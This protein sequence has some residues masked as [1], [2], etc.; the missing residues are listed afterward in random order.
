MTK[1][2]T[3]KIQSYLQKIITI[4][5]ILSFAGFLSLFP[6]QKANADI[7]TGL[8]GHWAL[9]EGSGTTA[10]DS[11]GNS[12]TGTFVDVPT[13]QAGRVGSGALQFDGTN[14][15]LTLA[16]PSTLN[17]NT[18]TISFWINGSASF[19][20][21]VYRLTKSTSITAFNS[22]YQIDVTPSSVMF[23]TGDGTASSDDDVYSTTLTAGS[24]WH[25]VCSLDG[26]N[27]KSCYRNGTLISSTTNDVNVTLNTPVAAYL[28]SGRP[29]T[30]NNNFEGIIDD[31]LVY[32]RALSESD[33][34]ELFA[35]GADT[36]DPSVPTNLATTSVSA[37]RIALSWNASTD[38][39]GVTGYYVYR[40]GVQIGSTAGTTYVNTGLSVNTTY[41]YTVTA[42]DQEGNESSQ[43]SP[44]EATTAVNTFEVIPGGGGD[45]TTIS[46][47]I[48]DTQPGDTCN[49]HAG[50]YLETVTP[51]VSGTYAY[52]ILIQTNSNDI[53]NL[54]GVNFDSVDF[55]HI[56]DINVQTISQWGITWTLDDYYKI[57]LFA[58]EDF[59][60]LGPVTINSISPSYDGTLNGWQVN[61]AVS[62]EQGFDGRVVASFNASLV[63]SLP[64]TTTAPTESIV[65]TISAVASEVSY[66]QTAAVLTVVSS[67][68]ANNGATI[69]RPPY[70]GTSKPIYTT[71]GLHTEYLSS[72]ASVGT[73]PSLATVANRFK[74]LRLEHLSFD[75]R[76]F[77]P[78]DAYGETSTDGYG[79]QVTQY[80]A[81]DILRLLLNDS[82]A[83]KMPA[84]IGVTQHGLD[85]AYAVIGGLR[86][87]GTGH[88]P[89]HALMA[90]F[91]AVMLDI[92]NAKTVL[93][94]ANDFEENNYTTTGVG[95]RSLWGLNGTESAYWTY[96]ISENGNRAN[97]DPYGFIDGGK[98]GATG[99]QAILSQSYKGSVLVGTLIPEI[100]TTAWNSTEWPILSGYAE[101]WVDTGFWAQPDPCAPYDGN[102]A[103][104]QITY[105]PDPA[106]PGMCILDTDL[107]YYNSSTDFAC[108]AGQ[109]CG[110]SYLIHGTQTDGGQ[111]KSN[112]VAAMW[113]AYYGEDFA[114]PIV[115]T[116]S[117][118][119]G[120]TDVATTSNLVLTFNE[121][122]AK[123][124]GNI[125]IK[126]TSDDSTAQTIDV[127]SGT[128][129][130][131]TNTVTINPSDFDYS[132]GYY[133]TMASGVL[134]DT[135]STPNAHA[136]ISNSTTWN[137]TTGA[138]PDSTTP[139]RSAGSP[140]G[141]QSAGTTQV[142]L[143]LTTDE[144]ATCKY[145]T[146][147][148]TAYGLM[149]D[150]FLTTGGTS[151]ST[152][153]SGLSNGQSYNYY[154]R[155]TDG[156]NANSDDY[157]ISFS[158]A[159]PA[160]TGGSSGSP[161]IW[162]LPIM[163]LNGF[164]LTINNGTPTTS[165]RNVT[166]NFN[167]GA[168]IKKMS[169]SMTRDFTDASQEDYTPTKQW[170]LCS[171]FG[172]LIKNP[173][174]PNGTYKV[175]A[176]FYTAYGRTSATALA[177]SSITL[178]TGATNTNTTKYNFTRNLSL[179]ATGKDV[180]ALQQ[181]LNANG[182]IISK[183]GAGSPG[184]ETTLFGALTYKALVKFQKSLGWSGT[185]FFGPMT[186][187]YIN[188]K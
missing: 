49:V 83:D 70:M 82:I 4:S 104:Y 126:K 149:T 16:T 168:D 109:Q 138:A 131:G 39:V 86:A 179:Y 151:H 148:G 9:D 28:A 87:P 5:L 157:T 133:I 130:V 6:P 110:R 38:N 129:N 161:A 102:P 187:A 107:Q 140:S 98:L 137:F 181:Y 143:S 69:F 17:A 13:W 163:P 156:S 95:G 172:G 59:W 80:N 54:T 37:S 147:A 33:I 93:V 61:P 76:D 55:V 7:T 139:V 62:A 97:K 159:S 8:L 120:A 40:N 29:D 58:N 21:T 45:Y 57:G 116:Y 176:Q 43:S 94:S 167:A 47:C 108:Q 122:V 1:F 74:K 134:T 145:S 41:S 18:Y 188:K 162:T 142:T 63:P 141:S 100:S 135:A 180:K 154:I 125:L 89:G 174:C 31:I 153:I 117:P 146:S 173:T 88:D 99:Y 150:T 27:V 185:G 35:L 119:D 84:L 32:N 155:C 36:T 111:Y 75:Q 171:K 170:D 183:T 68:P 65:K 42:Y 81:D 30:Q 128:V 44:V 72:L 64:Y 90:A 23:R 166:L 10:T 112:F 14:D 118:A 77:R 60:A 184:K 182:F 132:T 79:P 19:S 48:A 50:T 34:Q 152:T 51:A 71:S 115:N 46:G 175:Y 164:K 22:K 73:P 103:N 177:S 96:V 78:R 186:R 20:G 11:S 158:V 24:W 123:G 25:I 101:Q 178:T 106:N 144:S 114:S 127:T 15:A 66:I 3:P 160:S 165:N 26:S 121:N 91:G 113:G 12:H 136:G 67:T 124:T 169:I 56:Q 2:F 92:T 52:P 105:G 53:V 85:Q